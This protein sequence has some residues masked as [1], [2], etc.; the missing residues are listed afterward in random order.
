VGNLPVQGSVTVSQAAATGVDFVT[1]GYLLWFSSRASNWTKTHAEPLRDG[2]ATKP[3]TV[4]TKPRVNGGG[5][6]AFPCL[7]V[8]LR[9]PKKERDANALQ[10]VFRFYNAGTCVRTIRKHSVA[11]S[12]QNAAQS[13]EMLFSD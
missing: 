4:A 6:T 9:P 2:N 13:S 11:A 1:D 3:A 8:R 5:L 7:S 12:R 10:L